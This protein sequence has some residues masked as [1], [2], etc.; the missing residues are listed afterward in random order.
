MDILNPS[1]LMIKV[2][3][4]AIMTKIKFITISKIVGEVKNVMKYSRSLK[5]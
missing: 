3:C 5:C 2:Y 1:N 4:I